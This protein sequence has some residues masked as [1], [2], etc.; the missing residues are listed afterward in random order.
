[1]IKLRVCE[2]A[3]NTLIDVSDNE[4]EIEIGINESSENLINAQP[5]ISTHSEG[6]KI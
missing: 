1:M 6:P 2:E 5:Q 3:E 4:N